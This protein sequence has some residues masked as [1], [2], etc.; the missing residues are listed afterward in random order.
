[1]AILVV[2]STESAREST[3]DAARTA[4]AGTPAATSNAIFAV[5]EAW[6][7]GELVSID[8]AAE[9]SRLLHPGS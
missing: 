6:F 2:Y 4:F 1:Q 8:G 9:V 7:A 5:P 3:L